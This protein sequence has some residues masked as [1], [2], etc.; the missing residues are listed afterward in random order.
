[1]MA[2]GFDL[3]HERSP[4]FPVLQRLQ[5]EARLLHRSRIF[6]LQSQKQVLQQV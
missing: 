5:F 3:R 4:H 1:M 6:P 2:A